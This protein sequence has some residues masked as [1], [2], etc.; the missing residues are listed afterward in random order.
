MVGDHVVILG[1]RPN[2]AQ[3]RADTIAVVGTP[4]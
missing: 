2:P 4:E 3:H 1:T